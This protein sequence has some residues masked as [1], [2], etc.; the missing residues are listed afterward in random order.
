[1]ATCVK[2][3]CV[4]ANQNRLLFEGIWFPIPRVEENYVVDRTHKDGPRMLFRF[5]PLLGIGPIETISVERT[6]VNEVKITFTSVR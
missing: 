5:A 2:R 6:Q 1:M 3:L 4:D